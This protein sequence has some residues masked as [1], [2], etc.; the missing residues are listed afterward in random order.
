MRWLEGGP[1]LVTR[2]PQYYASCA[3]NDQVAQ[4]L[5]NIFHRSYTATAVASEEETSPPIEAGASPE[6][7][8]DRTAP[9]ATGT[10]P[11]QLPAVIGRK[12]HP[13]RLIAKGGMGAVY[14]VVHANT[15]E[16]LALKLM[17]AR[18]LLT[19][20]L[21][22]R[23]RREARIHSSVKSEHVVRVVDADVAPEL[24]DAP[25][26]VMELLAGQDFERLCLERE[27]STDEV[28]E[29]MRQLGTA[30]DKAHREGIVHR[31]LKPE[32]LFLAEREGLPP[33][34]KVLDFGIAK[35][36]AEGAGNSTATGQILGTPR[37][38]APEQAVGAKEISAAADRFA[39]GLIAFRLLSRR[40]Y[41]SGDNWVGLLRAVA[42]GPVTRPSSMGCDRGSPFDGW[43]ARACAL[44][45]GDRFSTCVEQVEALAQALAGVPMARSPWRR[46]R[47]WV[48]IAA[49]CGLVAS[50]WGL[51]YRKTAT[52]RAAPGVAGQASTASPARTAIASSSHLVSG[53]MHPA[54][55]PETSRAFPTPST[56]RPKRRRLA[57]AGAPAQKNG[58]AKTQPAEDRIW[59]EP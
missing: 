54:P 52:V 35:M 47:P 48:A 19:P 58:P 46:A 34:V 30:L 15:G 4:M 33:I 55:D 20:D 3:T 53:P 24:D 16:H 13:L 37:Y 31:D 38:M 14:E 59:D 42:R 2:R 28:V 5:H 18:S 27:P 43:F 9:A 57:R 26:L 32:N 56:E 29:W 1:L 10:V 8:A 36:A 17:L 44:Q 7:A 21:V 25:F 40:H 41:F 51:G 23:F 49:A 12:Y 50:V 11:V 45:P 6:R 39:L 22:E